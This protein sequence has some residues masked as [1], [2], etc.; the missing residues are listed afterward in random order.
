MLSRPT[1]SEKQSVSA[2][3][4]EDSLDSHDVFDGF[5]E[6]NELEFLVVGGVVVVLKF[7]NNW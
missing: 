3:E 4:A 1:H 5:V 2:T 7:F 6:E